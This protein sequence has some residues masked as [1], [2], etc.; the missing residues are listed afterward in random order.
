MRRLLL[1]AIILAVVG[2]LLTSEKTQVVAKTA[3][4]YFTTPSLI[5][6]VGD[7]VSTRVI[8][9]EGYTRSKYDQ[10][11]FAGYLQNF[12]LEQYGSKVVNYDGSDYG[13]Q[14]GHVATFDLSVPDNGLMQCADALMRLRCEYL[15]E[16]N[17]QEKIGF[18]FT[19][20][21]YCSWSQYA[22]GYRPI[23]NGNSVRFSKSATANYSKSNFYKYLNLI[24]TYAGTQSMAD[25]LIPVTD[26]QLLEVGDM[27]VSPGFPGHILIIADKA[28]HIDGRILLI[29]AQGN[30]P[31]QSVHII[32]NS[33]DSKL[34]PWHEIPSGTRYMI[35]TY[36]FNDFRFIRFK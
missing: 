7:S 12:K 24:Y 20:G 26:P 31:A 17:Q 10:N 14:A 3:K 6:K 19:S 33:N 2:F 15:W 4:T 36:Q 35:P 32:K 8:P 23:V 18:N 21:D 13:Y 5:N 28:V 29:F 1:V 11:S 34:S 27:M 22:A 16:T 25:E 30:T 9:P